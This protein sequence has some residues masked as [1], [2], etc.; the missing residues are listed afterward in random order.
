SGGNIDVSIIHRIVEKGL[1]T[2]GRH[3]K[4]SIVMPDVPGSLER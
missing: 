4:F 2:R 3:M 1:V